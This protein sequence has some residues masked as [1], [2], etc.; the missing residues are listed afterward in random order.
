MTNP[1]ADSP[2]IELYAEER[3]NMM[4]LWA[5]MQRKYGEKRA[6]PENMRM[7]K[8]EVEDRF[9]S[10]IGLLVSMD[11]GNIVPTGDGEDFVVS[12]IIQVMGRVV[13]KPF[14][15]EKAARETQLGHYDGVEGTVT[16]DGRI[17]E[18]TK[19]L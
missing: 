12:P 5:A 14:D 9:K 17:V 10:E 15:F 11:E 6:T 18:P 4:I 8:R 1:Y 2:E 3:A 7:M 19:Y 16:Q 13:E